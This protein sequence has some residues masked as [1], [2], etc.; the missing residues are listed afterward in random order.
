M[1]EADKKRKAHKLV[2]KWTPTQLLQMQSIDPA[3]LAANTHDY[4]TREDPVIDY[5]A[6]EIRAGRADWLFD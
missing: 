2:A 4:L 3:L 5:L 1:T 6:D